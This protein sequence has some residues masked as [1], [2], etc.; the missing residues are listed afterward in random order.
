[1][2]SQIST[3]VQPIAVPKANPAPKTEEKTLVQ[4]AAAVVGAGKKLELSDEQKTQVEKLKKIDQEVR[5]HEQAHKNSGGIY[6]SSASFSFQ[7]GPDGK[8]YAVGGEVSIDTS[9]VKDDP[10]ATIAKL[11]VVIA[12]ALAPAKP[13][14]QDI[15][16]ATA[17]VTARNQARNQLL[18]KA[19]EQNTDQ[20]IDT[21]PFDVNNFGNKSNIAVNEA[22]QSGN[23]LG[24][25]NKQAGKNYSLV[26]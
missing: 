14:S 10:E 9:P 24:L 22:Y 11:D 15:K 12:A 5:T 25:D 16:V 8:R 21:K 18:K 2:I 17:A 20:A 4:G 19:Q 1:M 23:D 6:A 13:S 26:S 3:H 7:V